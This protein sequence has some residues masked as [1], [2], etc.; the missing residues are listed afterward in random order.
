MIARNLFLKDLKRKKRFLTLEEDMADE[1]EQPDKQTEVDSYISHVL[2][3][4]NQLS[5]IDRTV[6]I[7]IAENDMSYRD[8]SQATGLSLSAIKVKIFRS[9]I[10]I[11]KMLQGGKIK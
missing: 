4:L 9:R 8:I 3:A 10:K 5:E 2:K 6:L 11:N 1:D 7:M